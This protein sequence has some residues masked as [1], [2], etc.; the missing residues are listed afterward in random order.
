M[1]ENMRTDASASRVDLKT[2]NQLRARID[3]RLETLFAGNE[4]DSRLLCAV[5]HGLLSPGKRLRPLITVLACTGAGGQLDEVIDA[6]CGVEMVHAASLIMDDLPSMDNAKLR[7]GA[8]TTHMVFGEG[9]AML[10]VVTL[11]NEAFCMLARA[12]AI[13]A[14]ARLR[15]VGHLTDAVG[16]D[17]LSGGQDMDLTCAGASSGVSLKEMEKRH[18][19]KTGALFRAAAAIGGEFAGADETAISNLKE[20]GCALGLAYQ[21]FDDVI[22]VACSAEDTGKDADQDT[23]KSTVVSLLGRD[24]ARCHAERQLQKAIDCA[25]AASQTHPAPLA[26]LARMIGNKFGKMTA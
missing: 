12:E 15:A 22:D 23:A 14:Q 24:G 2:I 19:E 8:L 3:E 1:S 21:A 7:R 10:A 13:P 25:E 11:L 17:G 6:A 16:I 4:A 20:F 26:E 9:A 18:L 5:R